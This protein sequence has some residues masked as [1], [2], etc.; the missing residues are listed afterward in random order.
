MGFKLFIPIANIIFIC[1]LQYNEPYLML[2]G[3]S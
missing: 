2:Q 1:F 3:F